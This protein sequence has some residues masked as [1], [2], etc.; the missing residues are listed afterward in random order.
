M[1]RLYIFG[2]SR[3]VKYNTATEYLTLFWFVMLVNEN[4]PELRFKEM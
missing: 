4:K 1:L 2:T 3:F